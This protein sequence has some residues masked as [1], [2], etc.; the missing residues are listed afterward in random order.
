MTS[1]KATPM[2]AQW[3]KCKDRVG[4]ALLLFRLGD[5]YEAFGEDAR[6]VSQALDLTLTKRQDTP[7]CGIPWHSSDG[8]IDRLLVKGFS[9]AIAEQMGAAD[10][11]KEGAKPLMDRQIVRILTPGTAMKGSLIQDSAHSILACVT[12]HGGRWGAACVDV[13]TALFH[14]FEVDSPDELVRELSRIRPKELICSSALRKQES[15]IAARLEESLGVR[16]TS[17]P[18]WTVDLASATTIVTTHFKTHSIDGFGLRDLPAAT[19][20]AGAVLCYLKETLLVPI[21]HLKSIEVQSSKARMVLDRCTLVNLDI[22]ESGSSTTN[23]KSLFDV[24]NGTKTPM[25]ARLLRNWLLSPLTDLAAIRER[26]DLVGS[27]IDFLQNEKA[28]AAQA[29][30]S[31]SSIRDIER[32]ILRIQAGSAGPRDVLFLAHCASHI[33]PLQRALQKLL[34]PL[35]GPKIQS[36]SPLEPL[37]E[38]IEATI[39]DEPPL[40][41]SDGGAIREGVNGELDELRC[42]QQNSHQWLVEYQSRLRDELGVKTLKVGY[43]RAF[44]YYIEVSRAQAERVPSTFC[45]RQTLT[46]AERYISEELKQFEDKV[47]TAEKKIEGLEAALFAE[48]KE[49]VSGFADAVLSASKAIAELDCFLALGHLAL[50]RSYC[51]P[52]MVPD[53][54][55]S[56]TDGRHPIAE[57]QVQTAFVPNNLEMNAAGP[58]LLLI[59]GPN[60]AGKSTF[61]RQAALFVILAQM[62]SFVPAS[63][64]TIGVVD[65]VFS[66]VGASDDLFRGQ[67]TFMV[68][69]TETASIL[70]QATPHSLILLD[71]IGRGTSTYDGIS[72][73]WAVAEYLIRFPKTNPRTLFATH[74]YEL[75]E[76]EQQAATV[77]N[78]TVAVSEEAGG[79]RFLYKVVPGRT[80]RSYGIHVARLAG[81]PE[82]VISRAAAV[83]QKLEDQRPRSTPAFVPQDLFTVTV[84]PAAAD[85]KLLASFEF[86]RDLDVV[87]LSPMDCFL[88]LVK[89]KKSTS[90]FVNHS[91]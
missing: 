58:S 69:M 15:V 90:T 9:V 52:E 84:G 35:L 21:P 24:I 72:I 62:G 14:V 68:E 65:R 51:R 29:I 87:R 32:L 83:L 61:V 50:F 23:A 4:E 20:A 27:C 22:F 64:A 46:G 67:S 47:L 66:R 45:R 89:F 12:T 18:S 81:L 76:L 25:G 26:H 37:V 19:C 77:K 91:S 75:T 44:G 39:V 33:R 17:I 74:Y 38:R 59:T 42:L 41:V 28:D 49:F 16:A 48:L 10:E 6:V 13:T 85:P 30:H 80:D 36:L 7:M 60:M 31:L 1:P 56:I 57:T 8:Y 79:I 88:K 40:R 78:M 55:L 54:V 2:M 3:A 82:A 11:A 86:L 70:N 73:A 53:P 34:H 43:T 71:E 63:K 5:F